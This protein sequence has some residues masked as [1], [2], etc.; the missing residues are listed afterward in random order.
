VANVAT[1]SIYPPIYGP[2]S[3]YQNVDALPGNTAVLTLW[4][5]TTITGGASKT[6]KVAVAMYPGAFLIAGVP[7]DEPKGSVEFAKQVQDPTTGV[8]IRIIKQWDN[9]LS[10][11]TTRLDAQWGRGIGL[12]EQG[13]VAIACA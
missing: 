11:F 6:G 2:G 3:H 8:S 12:A 9:V 10:R 7:L 5:G 1:L 4:P 13:S